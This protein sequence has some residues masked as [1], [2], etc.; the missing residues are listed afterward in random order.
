MTSDSTNEVP[1]EWLSTGLSAH[2]ARAFIDAGVSVDTARQWTDAGIEPDDAV[3]YLE[4][5]VSLK[6]AI[7]FGERGIAP[8]QI[9]RT[10]DGLQFD[11]EPWQEDPVDQLPDVI[12][13]G[14]FGLSLWTST[15]WSD[16][17][18]ENEVSFDWDG[19]HTIEWQVVSGAGLSVMSDVSSHGIASWPNGQDVLITYN[20]NGRLG[21]DELRSAAPTDGDHTG[22]KDPQRWVNFA[23]QLVNIVESLAD[24]GVESSDEFSDEYHCP[25]NDEWLDFD[26]M[27]RTFL[28]TAGGGAVLPDFADWLRDALEAGTYEIPD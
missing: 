5:A 27:F 17:P 2:D 13:P 25:A 21:Y 1:P 9:T 7:E 15:E 10:A 26:D 18:L 12:E 8:G 4:K 16:E 14:R 19:Q 11:L 6:D 20:Y 24:S 28:A 23:Q 3:D 22:A